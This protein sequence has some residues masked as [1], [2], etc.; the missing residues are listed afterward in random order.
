MFLGYDFV[1]NF[2]TRTQVSEYVGCATYCSENDNNWKFQSAYHRLSIKTPYNS[3]L[4]NLKKN[5]FP[6]I[7]FPVYYWISVIYM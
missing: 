4:Q 5:Y 7:I 3:V 1:D 2:F 6:I